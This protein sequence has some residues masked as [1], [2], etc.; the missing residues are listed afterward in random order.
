MKQVSA[1]VER[2][3]RNKVEEHNSKD[4]RYRATFRMLEACF[5]RGIGAYRTNPSSVRGNVGNADLGL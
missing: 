1:R 2:I 4:P 3:L 5:R